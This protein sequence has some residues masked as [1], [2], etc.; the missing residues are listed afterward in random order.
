MFHELRMV[1]NAWQSQTFEGFENYPCGKLKKNCQTLDIVQTMGGRSEQALTFFLY[2][3]LDIF[4]M[5]RGVRALCP[6]VFEKKILET[7]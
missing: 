3:C 6:K 5:E 2:E 7:W 4:L 1:K